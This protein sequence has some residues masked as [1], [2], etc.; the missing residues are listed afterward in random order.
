M[1]DT[2]AKGEDVQHAARSFR[3]RFIEYSGVW[4]HAGP[5]EGQGASSVAQVIPQ[6]AGLSGRMTSAACHSLS[7]KAHSLGQGGPCCAQ[8]RH[9]NP[10]AQPSPPGP[11]H[12]FPNV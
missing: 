4:F 2:P 6:P 11:G 12:S 3:E 5:D 9:R 10:P 1:V 7:H 8:D